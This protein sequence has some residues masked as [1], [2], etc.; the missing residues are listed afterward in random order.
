MPV[1]LEQYW[2]LPEPRGELIF[3]ELYGPFGTTVSWGRAL[4]FTTTKLVAWIEGAG[5]DRSSMSV[6][7]EEP[8][9]VDNEHV[10]VPHISVYAD[11]A[12]RVARR[13]AAVVYIRDHSA[14]SHRAMDYAVRAELL[15]LHVDEYWL[16]DLVEKR[17][18]LFN[19]GSN[20]VSAV[21]DPRTESDWTTFRSEGALYSATGFEMSL[22]ALFTFVEQVP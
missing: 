5:A 3:G 13:M 22:K 4:A 11:V 2:A 6:A 20:G 18:C 8:C 7:V 14:G 1:T 21:G 17:A 10:L 19:C 15:G 9:E 12:R 16:I